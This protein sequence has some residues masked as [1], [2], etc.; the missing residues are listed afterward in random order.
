VAYLEQSRIQLRREAALRRRRRRKLI[1]GASAVAAVA[2]GATALALSQDSTVPAH[3]AAPAIA[4]LAPQI[5]ISL[6]HGPRLRPLRILP[7][8]PGI[9]RVFQRG[10]RRAEIAL[11]FDDGDCPTCVARIIH[12]LARTGTHATIF[13]NGRYGPSWDPLAPAVRRLVAEARLT[14]GNHTFLHRDA[15]LESLA[16]LR[17]D[18]TAN[19]RWIEEKFQ[20]SARPFFRPP[21]GAYNSA[22]LAVAG[23]LGYTKVIMWSGTVADSSVRTTGYILDAIRHW[24]KPGAIILLH[25]NYPATSLA[26]PGII[27]IL[28]QRGLQPVTLTKLLG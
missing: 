3:R 9:A 4:S 11:T 17:S 6:H 13:P 1:V 12:F 8:H 23:E 16:A 22:T 26:L 14:I 18:L 25:G 19:E 5:G 15:L 28:R 24:A 27:A 2:A 20:V 7:A 21:Y 10:P